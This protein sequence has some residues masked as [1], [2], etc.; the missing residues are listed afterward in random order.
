MTTAMASKASAW[1]S[2]LGGGEGGRGPGE[3]ER[4]KND[5]G[6][7]LRGI[8]LEQHAGRGRGGELG[9]RV[10][11]DRSSEAYCVGAR[12]ELGVRVNPSPKGPCFGRQALSFSH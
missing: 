3:W 11:E 8:S 5:D 4:R 6:D 10:Y 12:W 9:V 2:M 7:G 1:S